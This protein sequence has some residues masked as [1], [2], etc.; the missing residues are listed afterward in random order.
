[1]VKTFVSCTVSLT[2]MTV[3][4]Q[5][6]LRH[7]MNHI[8]N[9]M[10][11][12]VRLPPVSGT[13]CPSSFLLRPTLDACTTILVLR[14]SASFCNCFLFARSKRAWPRLHFLVLSPALC[15]VTVTVSETTPFPTSELFQ[16]VV[17]QRSVLS[18]LKT[19]VCFPLSARF[20]FF[21]EPLS[22]P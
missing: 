22:L 4:T 5:T 2:F 15:A 21:P 11:L 3:P 20:P 7:C 18:Y 1:M 8:H 16:H 10:F 12:L 9:F 14:S 19:K 17:S 13:R 6:R